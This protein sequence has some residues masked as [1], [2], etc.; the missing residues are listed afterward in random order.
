[1][2]E[3]NK[4]EEEENKIEEEENNFVSKTEF[5]EL[6]NDMTKSFAQIVEL[7]K[8]KPEEKEKQI[9]EDKK[10]DEANTNIGEINNRYDKKAR[11]ILGDRV[12]RTYVEYPKGGG[13][14]FTIVIKKEFSNAGQE[15]LERMKEDRRTINIEREEYRG[16]DGVEKWAKLI[17][18]NLNRVLK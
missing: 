2:E 15:Y 8:Q 11:E 17:L 1:M 13:T 10:I 3:D 4:I 6:K 12:E 16:E 14:L 5:D 9:A 18:Q 7:I